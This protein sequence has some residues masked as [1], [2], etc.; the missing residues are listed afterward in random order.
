MSEI[1]Y[2]LP[3]NKILTLRTGQ[4][5]AVGCIG[6]GNVSHW[7]RKHSSSDIPIEE[8]WSHVA[9]LGLGLDG[10]AYVWESHFLSRGVNKVPFEIWLKQNREQRKIEVFEY[11][12]NVYVLDVI[13]KL[14]IKYGTLD[15][16]GLLTESKWNWKNIRNSDG[17][18]CSEYIALCDYGCILKFKEF[19]NHEEDRVKPVHYKEYSLANHLKLVDITGLVKC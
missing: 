17:L 8:R 6:S 16:A 11:K 9:A 2:Q 10:K 13:A 7:I 12:L 1:T 14:K 3:N 19:A 15:I 18:I 4:F 5:Y